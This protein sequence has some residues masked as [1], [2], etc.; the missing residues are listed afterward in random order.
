MTKKNEPP[1]YSAGQVLICTIATEEP[2]GYNVALPND[3]QEAFLPTPFVFE[4]G[5]KVEV[6]FVCAQRTRLLLA[7]SPN[8]KKKERKRLE[9]EQ[10]SVEGWHTLEALATPVS[11]QLNQILR[12]LEELQAQLDHSSSSKKFLAAIIKQVKQAIKS[13]EQE[14]AVSRRKVEGALLESDLQRQLHR[15]EPHK[16]QHPPGP[17]RIDW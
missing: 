5:E 3:D 12:D 17:H 6:V 10:S 1:K 15:I 11:K 16:P 7:I 13:L 9:R 4:I 14:N 8:E 2:G